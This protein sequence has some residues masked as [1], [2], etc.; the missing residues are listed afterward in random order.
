MRHTAHLAAAAAA[1]SKLEKETYIELERERAA[2]L[3]T[4]PSATPVEWWPELCERLW[5]ERCIVYIYLWLASRTLGWAG[6][7][8]LERGFDEPA[9]L[10]ADVQSMQEQEPERRVEK[11]DSGR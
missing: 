2:P 3:S 4:R 9:G 8:A 10:P 7:H 11:A 6:V 1:V 5:P